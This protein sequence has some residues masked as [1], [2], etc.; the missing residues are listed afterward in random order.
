MDNQQLKR[1]AA[2]GF[3]YRFAERALAKSI[4]F[5]VQLLLA[6]LLM[7]EEYGLIALVTVVITIC[8]VFVTYGF[9]NSLVVNKESDQL[10]FSTCFFFCVTLALLLYTGLF[11]ASPLIASFYRNE[12]LTLIL[13]VMGLRIPL[14]AVNSVQHAYVAKHLNFRKRTNLLPQK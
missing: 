5:V 8:D 1:K 13:R 9:G 12:Q 11:F 6:R 10:D 2:S 3:I 7:P 4:S 14:A